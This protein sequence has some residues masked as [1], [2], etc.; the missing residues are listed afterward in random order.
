MLDM[1]GWN[2]FFLHIGCY[3]PNADPTDGST[4]HLEEDKSPTT[5]L[6]RD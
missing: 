2:T 4:T 1:L 3:T 6:T 5:R